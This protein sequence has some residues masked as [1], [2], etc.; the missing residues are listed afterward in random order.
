MRIPNTPLLAPAREEL[1]IVI[2]PILDHY[3]AGL[4]EGERWLHEIKYDGYRM[5]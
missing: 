2:A 3:R 4:K 5:L 1:V